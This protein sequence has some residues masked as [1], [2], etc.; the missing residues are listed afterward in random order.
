MWLDGGMDE[1]RDGWADRCVDEQVVGWMTGKKS[2]LT[3]CG[4]WFLLSNIDLHPQIY[5]WSFCGHP[6]ICTEQGTLSHMSPTG[7]EN[8]IIRLCLL[9]LTPPENKPNQGHLG[10]TFSGAVMSSCQGMPMTNADAP[11]APHRQSTSL[12]LALLLVWPM[13]MSLPRGWLKDHWTEAHRTSSCVAHAM[14]REAHGKWIP[15][16][17]QQQ[18]VS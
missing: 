9:V 1:W 18:L 16:E 17:S 15:R 8:V 11:C 3:I 13:V 6:W 12:G 7:W 4:F 5:L 10:T 14:T 2:V